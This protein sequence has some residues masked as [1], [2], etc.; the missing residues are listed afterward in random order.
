[1]HTLYCPYLFAASIRFWF[2]N[3]RRHYSRLSV[4]LLAFQKTFL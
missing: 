2:T 1:M 3:S 4:A